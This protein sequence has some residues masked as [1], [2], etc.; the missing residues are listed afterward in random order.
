MQ[1]TDRLT[2]LNLIAQAPDL[3]LR[4]GQMA[5]FTGAYSYCGSCHFPAHMHKRDC[6]FM[7]GSHVSIPIFANLLHLV[8]SPRR[9]GGRLPHRAWRADEPARLP[10]P[11]PPQSPAARFL[12]RRGQGNRQPQAHTFPGHVLVCVAGGGGVVVGLFG[13]QE[14]RPTGWWLMEWEGRGV[15][16][17]LED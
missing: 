14:K 10:R 3:C 16:L 6:Q 1:T 12:Q 17:V 2:R 15:R 7:V 4:I 13:R 5:S 8:F 11:R 9:A